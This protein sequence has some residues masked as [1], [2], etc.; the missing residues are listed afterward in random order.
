MDF[1]S[2]RTKNSKYG[3]QMSA[4]AS[5]CIPPKEMMLVEQ[6]IAAEADEVDGDSEDEHLFLENTEPNSHETV[7]AKACISIT[8]SKRMIIAEDLLSKASECFE[9]K[10]LTYKRGVLKE[11]VS[12]HNV[13]TKR[14]LAESRQQQN[15]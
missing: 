13:S 5:F 2:S 10:V 6:G 14:Q 12:T 3:L 1:E 8:K 7:P 9:T 11:L 15:N 4:K